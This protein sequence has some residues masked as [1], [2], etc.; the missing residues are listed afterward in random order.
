MDS[1]KSIVAML[2]N[3][4]EEQL[5]YQRHGFELP[6]FSFSR[7]VYTTLFKWISDTMNSPE[8]II[9]LLYIYM[10]GF[11][12]VKLDPSFQD[13][14]S[15]TCLE[16]LARRRPESLSGKW[17]E[18]VYVIV[19][20]FKNTVAVLDPLKKK[21]KPATLKWLLEFSSPKLCPNPCLRFELFRLKT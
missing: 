10:N 13:L 20:Y 2:R 17:E 6:D 5:R 4:Q 16:A 12:G 7:Q 14:V 8:D 19:K 1:F 9:R 15:F 3:H 11:D 18:V 21:V